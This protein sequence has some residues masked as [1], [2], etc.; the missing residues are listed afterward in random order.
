MTEAEA[1]AVLVS[2]IPA[3]G[4]RER[5]LR[6]AGGIL[7][8]LEEPEA[9]RDA[10]GEEGVSA[11]RRAA[12]E[13]D[14]L[15]ER[16]RRQ[17]AALILRGSREYP[18]LLTETRHPP[19]LLFCR[20][21]A[22]LSDAPVIAAVGTRDASEYGL[23]HARRIA[24]ELAAAG[25][26]VVSGLALGI[27]AASH[28]GALDAG[29]RT[30]AVLGGALD[31]FYPS[32]NRPLTE[33]ICEA[34]GSVVSEYAP[35]VPPTRFSFLQRNRIIAGMALGVLIA[36]GRQRSGALNTASTALDEGREVFALPGSLDEPASALPHRLIA[37]GARLVTCGADIL[38][39]LRLTP[40]AERPRG[41]GAAARRAQPAEAPAP[42]R[43]AKPKK[44]APAKAPD[45]GPGGPERLA[46]PEGLSEAEAAVCRA[47]LA[48]PAEYDAVSLATGLSDD[49]L[50]ALLIEMEMDGLVEALPGTRYAAGERMRAV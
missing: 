48:G 6:Q 41:E 39:E 20:G 10:L 11:L 27:D 9:A 1:A 34:G 5:A 4:R 30:V 46:V 24:G 3:Y 47:L 49:E 29:G 44:R 7:R 23:R 40:A 19:L 32:E 16:L 43:E 42:G 22:D 8:L 45:A 31:R 15:L 13:S 36:E 38:E 21:R 50:G 35:G 37:E 18:P 2:A 17:G 25:C 26:C 12:A 14:R 28:L 33:R